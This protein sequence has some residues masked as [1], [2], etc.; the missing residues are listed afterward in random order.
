MQ[1][2]HEEKILSTYNT[3]AAKKRRERSAK[4]QE[5]LESFDAL[6][7]TDDIIDYK[8][9][10]ALKESFYSNIST[11]HKMEKNDTYEVNQKTNY[12]NEQI[13]NLTRD[14]FFYTVYESLLVD[15]VI[16]NANYQ[17]IR[18]HTNEFY[19]LC[20]QNG[21]M[22]IKEN[23]G[24]DDI[25][26]TGVYMLKEELVNHNSCDLGR[27]IENTVNSENMLTSYVIECIKLKTADS[28]KNEKKASIIKE[29][30]INEEKYVD[31]SKSLFRYLF[32]N[33]IQ[34]TIDNT[35]LTDPDNLQDMAM[36]ET[37][38]DYTIM[39]TANT[40]KLVEFKN[41]KAICNCK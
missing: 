12:I 3:K 35:D 20:N 29:S 40:L 25:F 11:R 23:S 28:L 13:D 6:R 15:D 22:S 7:E 2:F 26:Q 37:I 14:L 32:E 1:H 27:V 10:E 9:H 8:K 31:P 30:L 41:L 33:N 19:D 17:Y 4:T 16:K 18:E 34:E 38:L 5:L 24:F 39:E 36:L 21:M